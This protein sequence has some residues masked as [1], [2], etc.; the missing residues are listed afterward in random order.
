VS[1]PYILFAESNIKNGVRANLGPKTLVTGPS[2]SGKSA[3]TNTIELAVSGRVSDIQGRRDVGKEIELLQL[4]PSVGGKRTELFARVVFSDGSEASWRVGGKGKGKKAVHVHPSFVDPDAAF[5]LRAV[6]DAVIGNVETARK[7]FLQHAVGIISDKDVL[8]RIPTTSHAYF[9]RATLATSDSAATPVDRLLAALEHAKKEARAASDLAKAGAEA[10]NANAS[11]LP[12][13]PTEAEDKAL[14]DAIRE[15]QAYLD[16]LKRR[17]AQVEALQ[18]AATRRDEVTE[19]ARVARVAAVEAR[20]RREEAE[21]ALSTIPVPEALG[22]DVQS[23]SASIQAHAAAG[24]HD[25]LVCGSPGPFDHQQRLARLEAYLGSVAAQSSAYN[26]AR[27]VVEAAMIAERLAV[28]AYDKAQQSLADVLKLLE[29]G[30]QEIPSEAKIAEAEAQLA[31]LRSRQRDADILRASW[32]SSQKARDSSKESEENAAKW[33][34]LAKEC[35]DA[36]LSLLDSGVIGFRTRV[37]RFLPPA[38]AFD[39]ALREG[40][41]RVFRFGRQVDGQLNTA[42]SGGEWATIMSA[43]AAV[44]RRPDKFAAIIPDDR[45]FDPKA[46]LSVLEAFRGADAQVVVTSPI[47]PDVVP[48]GWIVVDTENGGT[49]HG[50]PPDALARE[51]E[52]A[53]FAKG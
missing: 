52:A 43:M 22:R 27:E 48:A 15:A 38:F 12:P 19:Q 37:Q 42:L 26:K 53:L 36:V 16:G 49:Q 28:N 9:H 4:A 17:A 18:G 11:G 47:R 10:S 23:V 32:G 40:D 31:G 8:D 51:R 3:V 20:T 5:P 2:F 50:A 45:Q 14:A 44:C 46:F 21:R 24:R 30:P 41:S 13:L 1:L 34:K 7:F 39:I 25:C 29:Q 35:Q 6:H 33:A